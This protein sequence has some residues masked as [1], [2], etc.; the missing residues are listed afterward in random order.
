MN[1]SKPLL[2]FAHANSFPAGTYRVFFEYLRE[3][4]DVR[5]LP[6]HA[7]DP[8]YPVTDG[9]G[10]LAQEL[11]AALERDYREPVI[12]VG[13]SLGGFLC[14][15]TAV[16]RPELVRCVVL[17]DSP[18]VAGWR[19]W[20]VKLFKFLRWNKRYSPAHISGVSTGRMRKQR[21]LTLRLK[22]NFQF[23]RPRCCVTIFR[24]D[25]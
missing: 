7:H 13:H 20:L 22:K 15:L 9:W 5:A 17:L 16:S 3:H 18:I 6:L 12:L 10:E 8:A 1:S 2:H 11:I 19:A 4:Y 25:W 14:L 24:V 23:G 21:W